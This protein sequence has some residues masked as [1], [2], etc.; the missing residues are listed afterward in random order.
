MVMKSIAFVMSAALATLVQPQTLSPARA[1]AVTAPDLPVL[2]IAVGEAVIEATVDAR[3]WV[4]GT[5]TIRGTEPFVE[6][7]AR[8]VRGWQFVPAEI[9]GAAIA[10]KV[11]VAAVF[12]QPAVYSYGQPSDRPNQRPPSPELPFPISIAE[13]SFPPLAHSGGVVVIEAQIGDTGAVTGA[14]VLCSAPPFDAPALTATH[15]WQFRPARVRGV[16]VPAFAYIVFG[17]PQPV[18]SPLQPGPPVPRP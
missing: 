12:R 10:S 2:T 15:Q 1:R 6:S 8:S 17:F 5:A 13:P 7:V 4:A 14:T 18:G 16:A 3:G 9:D 11:L